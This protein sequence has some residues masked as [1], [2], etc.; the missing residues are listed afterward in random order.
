MEQE[1]LTNLVL[2]N[3]SNL[4]IYGFDA[5]T[6]YTR[7]SDLAGVPFEST[8]YESVDLAIRVFRCFGIGEC[9]VSNGLLKAVGVLFRESHQK[10]KGSL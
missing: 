5:L 4:R 2:L 10:V 7:K 8:E 3:G 1:L 9:L 6:R